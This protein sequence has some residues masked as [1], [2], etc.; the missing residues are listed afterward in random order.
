MAQDT[1]NPKYPEGVSEERVGG[2]VYGILEYLQEH[3]S[4]TDITKLEIALALGEAQREVGNW[5]DK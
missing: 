4:A 2:A 3:Y 5:E 1:K